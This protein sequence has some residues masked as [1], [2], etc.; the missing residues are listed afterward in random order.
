[1]AGATRVFSAFEDLGRI[2]DVVDDLGPVAAKALR[3]K[4]RATAKRRT[5]DR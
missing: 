2:I 5:M 4:I 3:S 1:M